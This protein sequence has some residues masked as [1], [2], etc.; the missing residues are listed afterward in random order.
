MPVDPPITV[1]SQPTYELGS[2]AA[3]ML[4]QRLEGEEPLESQVKVLPVELVVRQSCG[5]P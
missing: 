4:I 5:C 3:R 2:T 1:V